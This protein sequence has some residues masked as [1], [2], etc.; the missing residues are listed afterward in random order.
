M[1]EEVKEWLRVYT[2]DDDTTIQG[3]ID[4]AAIYISNATGKVIT[5]DTDNALEKLAIKILCAYW[6]E[7]PQPVKIVGQVSDNL[8][9]S[10][11][12]IFTQI[13]YC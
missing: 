6:F 5:A 4:A 1:L 12:G 3:L 8:R 10:L 9:H 2:P 7:N 11:D 13:K